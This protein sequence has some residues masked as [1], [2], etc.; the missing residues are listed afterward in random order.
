LT[1]IVL[2]GGL[3]V[4]VFG[5]EML[6][7]HAASLAA[8]LRVPA[9]VIGLTIVA[10][11]TSSPELTISTLASI[12]G[13][14]AIALGNVIGSNIFNV[15]VILGLSALV[16]PLVISEQLDRIDV[17]AM[18]AVSML[19]LILALDGDVDGL[20]GAILLALFLGYTAFQFRVSR[21]AAALAP[22]AT[23]MPGSLARDGVL[24]LVGL[25]LLV[26]GARWFLEGAVGI[27]RDFGIS[28]IVIGLTIVAAG[29]SLP[30]AA[31]SI[32]AAIRGHRDIAVGNVV[33]SNVFNVLVVLGAAA[34]AAPGGIPVPR[35]AVVFDLP[36]MLAVAVA[37]LPV[38][39][40]RNVIAR[41]QGA[42]FVGYYVLYVVYL[43]LDMSHHDAL[44][45]YDAVM[46][47]FVLPITALTF[48]I[49]AFRKLSARGGDSS[50]GAD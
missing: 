21:E 37:C 45:E 1:F 15:L 29:S 10:F 27:A 8:R 7:R 28:E 5:A 16:A 12:D 42:V 14:S 17:P 2:V 25:A 20:D 36:V 43:I 32:V 44:D 26:L 48:G 22:P 23:P 3:A 50:G 34:L 24:I 49:L 33:G 9:L 4:L 13:K 39:F 31:T 46:L 41:W 47:Q 40:E 11:G 38:F 30:E 35:S 6:V 19:A 18:V